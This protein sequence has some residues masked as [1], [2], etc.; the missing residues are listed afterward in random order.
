MTVT[1]IR[2][3]APVPDQ[4]LGHFSAGFNAQAPAAFAGLE[5]LRQRGRAAF[6]AVGLPTRRVEA[7]KY[8]D[9]RAIAR[10]DFALSD[11]GGH[12][13]PRGAELALELDA[14]RMVFVDGVFDAER[15]ALS[16]LPAGVGV[17]PL[18][19]YLSR[20]EL[21]SGLASMVDERASA[22]TALNLAFTGEG[23]VIEVGRGVELD[24]P[25]YLL[26]VS[27]A[28]E[29]AVMSH[30]RVILRLDDNARATVLEHFVGESGAA[31]LTNLVGEA[32]LAPGSRLDHY[33]LN[34]ASEREFHFANFKI[35]QARDSHFSSHSL[36][37]GGA[38]TRNDLDAELN[39]EGAQTDFWGLFFAQGRQ[40]VDNHTVVNHNV[41]RTYSNENYKGILNDRAR[42]VFNGRVYIKRDAQQVRGY[43][44]NAN[45]LLSDR[46]EID[47]KPELEIYADDVLCS[48]GA[49][50]GQLDENAVFALRARGIDQHTARALLTLAF[51]GEILESTKLP[52]IAHRVER[53]VAGMLPER[54]NLEGLIE[55]GE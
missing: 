4:A 34:E 54:F 44:N 30:P 45:L 55:L 51:A 7:W 27:T 37:L 3:D 6:E 35:D 40:H 22:F 49:T 31:N 39:G 42:G 26:F 38:L 47:T 17:A 15:S 25:V 48:H 10:T 53:R 18:S 12:A 24:R 8:T 33:K 52:E 32:F 29:R 5:R 28:A 20:G 13:T 11:Q 23:A 9:V 41:V 2:P 46:A 43:Q 1:A 16:G 50:T 19:R 21:P 36:N 14:Y